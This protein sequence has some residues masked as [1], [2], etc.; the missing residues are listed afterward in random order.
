VK[1]PRF[2]IAWVMVAVAIV[3]LDVWAIGAV[4]DLRSGDQNMT[5]LLG[6]GAIPMAN[7]LAISQLMRLRRHESPPFLLGFQAFGAIAMVLFVAGAIF[8]T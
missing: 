1:A 7:I 8:F 6:T 4:Y 3:A 5:D 2:R